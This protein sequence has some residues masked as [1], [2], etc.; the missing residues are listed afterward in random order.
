MKKWLCD[1]FGLIS[2]IQR[3]STKDGP[4]LRTTVFLQGCTLNCFWCHNP[5]TIDHKPQL[6]FNRNKCISCGICAEPD[7][8]FKLDTFHKAEGC[9][10]KALTVSGKRMQDS[11]VL[12][13]ILK[14]LPFYGEE[15]GVTFSGGEPLLQPEF[16]ASLLK[17]C[18]D[19]DLNTAVDTAGNVPWK[20]IGMIADLVDVFLY[21][22][23]ALDTRLHKK[24]TGADNC[25]ILE[26]LKNLLDMGKRIIIR[27]PAIP[28]FND[29]GELERIIQYAKRLK[30][31]YQKSICGIETLAYHNLGEDKAQRLTN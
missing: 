20:N 6:M 8:D 2:N 27:I 15:G 29:G 11:A 14:D 1:M 4:G 12:I 30:K 22:I 26:N 5:E 7:P 21:D 25:L 13:E 10:A 31:D 9:P 17:L 19:K 3:C 24:G 18:K 23:K 28:G 16:L